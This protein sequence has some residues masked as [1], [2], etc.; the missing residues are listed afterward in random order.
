M[1]VLFKDKKHERVVKKPTWCSHK[2]WE[3]LKG[4][5]DKGELKTEFSFTGPERKIY[6][7]PK[8][9]KPSIWAEKHRVLTKSRL[10][11]AWKNEVTPYSVGIMDAM[12]KPYVRE[13]NIGK[14]PQS[15]I[16]EAIITF[17][18][19]RIDL[20]AGDVLY[21]FPDENTAKEN[22]KDRVIPMI[23][24]SLRLKSYLTDNENDLSSTRINLQHMTIYA[25][26]AGSDARLANK[27]IRYAVSDEIDKP[28]FGIG[29]KEASPLDLIDKRLITNRDISKHIKI[30][31]FSDEKGNINQELKNNT[32]VIFDYHVKCPY[33]QQRQLMDMKY[34]KW[35][36]GGSA[37]HLEIKNKKMAWYECQHCTAKWD[38]NDRNKAVR[39]TM[40]DGWVARGTSIVLDTYLEKF[41]PAY[42]G[43]H[44]P[45]W[46]SYFIS[47]SECAAAFIQGLKSKK[48]LKDFLNGFAAQPWKKY[49]VI[50]HQK[51]D[52]VLKCK[53]DLPPQMAP[54]SAVALTAGI[55]VQKAGF[56]YVIRAWAKD[57]TNWNIDH[58]Y[59]G[60]WADVEKMLFENIYPVRG[61]DRQLRIWRA[62]IDTGGGKYQGIS[63][64]EET[65]LWL[66]QYM[67]G[68]NGCRIW[69]AKGSSNP[70]PQKLKMGSVLNKTPSGRALK[71]GMRLAILDTDK[72]KDMFFQRM[73]NAVE[74]KIGGAWLHNETSIEYA[75]QIT[76][77]VKQEDDKGI[78]TW[79]QKKEDNHYIDCECLASIVADWE[80][81]GGGVNLFPD[82]TTII[83]KQKVDKKEN[84]YTGGENFWG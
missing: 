46:I 68:K 20:A 23:E 8:Q 27:P 67:V 22:I 1:S 2:L 36:G 38:D 79:V 81:P 51:E 10:I 83:K 73:E 54:E 9:I 7:K 71:R 77:E 14:V 82:P 84:P 33:C 76:A 66:Q 56:W 37:N 59:L 70:L 48:K 25:A 18:G 42:L 13:G 69:G 49:E 58:G 5:M 44:L 29:K 30:S 41:R 75:R 80:W 57:W 3:T 15:G 61:S 28:G 47:L 32:D 31:S 12:A 53:C 62:A 45:G 24:S 11:G 26:W 6:R 74:G 4:L 21:T 40:F 50:T 17:I 72:I 35:D 19:S 16:S 78:E 55:D 60:N 52:D 43:F 65:Y 34:I 39:S 63:S 64:T